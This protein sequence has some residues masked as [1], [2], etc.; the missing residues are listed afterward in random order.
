MKSKWID[1]V[2]LCKTFLRDGLCYQ[3]PNRMNLERVQTAVD[4]HPSE[5]SLSLEIMCIMHL[6]IIHPS[7][8][9]TMSI[10]KKL[11]HNFRKWGGGGGSKAVWNVSENSSYLPQPSFH[12]IADKRKNTHHNILVL[13]TTPSIIWILINSG[14]KFWSSW[15]LR[16]KDLGER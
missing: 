5:W 15:D 9:A 14:Q 10:I 13:L 8:H 2:P 12:K 16:W 7:I 3:I 6:V 1:E 11:Q 4:P